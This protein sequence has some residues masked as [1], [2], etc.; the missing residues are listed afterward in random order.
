MGNSEKNAA[1]QERASLVHSQAYFLWYESCLCRV[2]II[3]RIGTLRMYIAHRQIVPNVHIC[4]R[5]VQSPFSELNMQAGTD[6]NC[7]WVRTVELLL[8]SLRLASLTERLVHCCGHAYYIDW[9]Y[10]VNLFRSICSKMRERAR[11]RGSNGK[12]T[13]LDHNMN[14]WKR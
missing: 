8:S 12:G 4:P 11:K 9:I 14:Q 13:C 6:I 5:A 3:E 10:S 2:Q 1:I 7:F